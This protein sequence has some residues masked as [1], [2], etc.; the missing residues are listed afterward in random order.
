MALAALTVNVDV[1]VVVGV[2]EIT[3][4]VGARLK[5]VG[6]AP[7]STLHVMGA[8]PVAVTVRLYAVPLV[9]SGNVEVVIVGAVPT[10][11]AVMVTEQVSVFSP[12]VVV[13]VIVAVPAATAVTTPFSTEAFVSSLVVHVTAL[14]A[15]LSGATVAVRVS[16]SPTF[17]ESAL[18]S[19]VTPVT[20]MTGT[21]V[22]PLSQPAIEKPIIVTSAII[23]NR[24]IVFFI[25]NSF[26]RKYKIGVYT[27][28][29]RLSSLAF[30]AT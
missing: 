25:K 11:T 14:F 16:V 13:T 28:F 4:V 1:P 9:P 10:L 20:A 17:R 5:P 7:L 29:L 23:P 15:A 21:L 2:P 8:S 18:L 6:N 27:L 26:M 12:S 24:L 19:S 22:V 30:F 3:P